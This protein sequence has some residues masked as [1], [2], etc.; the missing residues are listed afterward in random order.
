MKGEEPSYS[1]CDLTVKKA[2][3]E[4]DWGE[5]KEIKIRCAIT[6]KTDIFVIY[7]W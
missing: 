7:I 3:W 4:K 2:S 1:E 5:K 6:H